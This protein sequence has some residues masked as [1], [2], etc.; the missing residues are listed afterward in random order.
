[1]LGVYDPEKQAVTLRAVPV[2]T[3]GRSV[4]ALAQ[5]SATAIERGT[6]DTL[7]YTQARRN[8]GEAFGNKRQKQ[9]ARNLDRMKV[10]TDNM[11][12][13]LADVATGIDASVSALPSDAELNA[14]L[15]ASRALPE[16]N[17]NAEDPADV[18]ALHA[19]VPRTVLHTLSAQS[20][21]GATSQGELARRIGPLG[22]PSPWLLPR[23]WHLV[24]GLENSTDRSQTKELIRAGYYVAV[25]LAFRRSARALS[26]SDGEASVAQK[27][28]LSEEERDVVMD[29]LVARFTERTR[30]DQTYVASLPR[31]NTHTADP[32]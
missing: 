31:L 29:D 22:K 25:L 5:L 1:M 10:R 17:V 11:D 7:N 18:Y 23:I 15:N 21:F 13:V 14:A 20:L 30:T 8:L 19:L 4:K 24:Q 2:F 26:S 6:G 12:H 32:S 3:L 16:A 28:R 9:T 27:M